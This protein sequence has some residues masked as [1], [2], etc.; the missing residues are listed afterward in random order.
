[1]IPVVVL[2]SAIVF[3]LVWVD[4]K[5]PEVNRRRD[6]YMASQQ[7]CL[8]LNGDGRGA[9]LRRFNRPGGDGLSAA[10]SMRIVRFKALLLA[11]KFRNDRRIR[12]SANN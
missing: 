3:G 11:A 12:A 4:L 9:S 5:I 7:S 1:M 2:H 10:E 8:C 6:F